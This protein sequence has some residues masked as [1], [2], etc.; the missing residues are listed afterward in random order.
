MNNNQEKINNLLINYIIYFD[1]LNHL[2]II[3]QKG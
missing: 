3:N 1:I 2:I